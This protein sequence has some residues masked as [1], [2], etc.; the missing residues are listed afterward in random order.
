MPYCTKCGRPLNDGEQCSC[1]M[2]QPQYPLRYSYDGQLLPLPPKKKSY[3]FL[4]AI[5]IYVLCAFALVIALA[6]A[7]VSSGIGRL[8]KQRELTKAA[9]EMTEA[10]D[11]A[12][13]RISDEGGDIMGVSIITSGNEIVDG[14]ICPF[15]T[16]RFREYFS[17]NTKYS[18][19]CYFIFVNDGKTEYLAVSDSWHDNRC[20]I[21]TYPSVNKAAMKYSADG[22][23]KKA[24][25][26]DDFT[27]LYIDS[28]QELYRAN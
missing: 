6:F 10:A 24:E 17:E 20:P 7:P 19:R 4:F 21:G 23:V 13:Q 27:D 12:L 28:V 9:A 1:T 2:T 3:T 14:F 5:G 25:K 11:K 18:D 26:D 22:S 8:K 15:D 16:D